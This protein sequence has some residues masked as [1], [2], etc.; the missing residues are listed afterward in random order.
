MVA[1][2]GIRKQTLLIMIPLLLLSLL[3]RRQSK[4][5]QYTII[6]ADTEDP[7][8]FNNWFFGANSTA[9]IGVETYY[10]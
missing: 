5:L 2:F 7:D 9:C 6:N 3:K 1:R 10:A 8:L 4:L